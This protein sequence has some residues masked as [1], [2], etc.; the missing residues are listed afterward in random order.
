MRSFKPRILSVISCPLYVIEA[1]PNLA[2]NHVKSVDQTRDS[3]KKLRKDY[4]ERRVLCFLRGIPPEHE[5][6]SRQLS[7]TLTWETTLWPS[8][9]NSVLCFI[10]RASINLFLGGS[11]AE[12]FDLRLR[13]MQLQDQHSLG[14]GFVKRHNACEHVRLFT[15][16]R[17]SIAPFGRLFAW[18][19]PQV[20]RTF[21]ASISATDQE[22]R[23]ALAV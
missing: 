5:R 2:Y 23:A 11:V 13:P 21:S 15:A 19:S 16:P 1:Y 14:A 8:T 17:R 10:A 12:F 4:D 3:I 18:S 7:A 9:K 22:M 20:P 6:A